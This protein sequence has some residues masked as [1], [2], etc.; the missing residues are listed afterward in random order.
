[1]VKKNKYLSPG[2]PKLESQKIEAG[3]LG[4]FFGTGNNALNS[5]LAL[6]ALGLTITL[7]VLLCNGETDSLNLVIPI[8]TLLIGY[9]AGNVKK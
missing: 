4:K 9:L 3:W 7:I 6:I 8:L 1:M 5:V 2:N